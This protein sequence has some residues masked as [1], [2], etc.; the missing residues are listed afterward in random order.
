MRTEI[1]EHGTTVVE[2]CLDVNEFKRLVAV[3]ENALA[4]IETPASFPLELKSLLEIVGIGAPEDAR[5]FRSA[6][7][8]RVICWGSFNSN[9]HF[10]QFCPAVGA[11][12]NHLTPF[13]V[14]AIR[15]ETAHLTP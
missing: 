12:D 5:S 11:D 8:G 10:A 7:R 3:L 2:Q 9:E 1:V 4:Q 14:V 15:V 6:R 13:K